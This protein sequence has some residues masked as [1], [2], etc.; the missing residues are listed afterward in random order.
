MLLLLWIFGIFALP[1]LPWKLVY[2]SEIS[3]GNE[4]VAKIEDF[5]RQYHRLPDSDRPEQ[6]TALGFELGIG[7]KPEYRPLGPD[8]YE[9]E[10]YIGFDGPRIIYSSKTK[11][12]DRAW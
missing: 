11:Q 2:S 4:I 10:Y 3:Q 9:I 8:A 6:L 1:Y 12:W 5:R 7:Y